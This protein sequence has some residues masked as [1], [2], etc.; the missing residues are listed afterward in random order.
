MEELENKFKEEKKTEQ[1]K[2]KD[3]ENLI[4]N[5]SVDDKTRKTKKES[6]KCSFVILKQLL[7]WDLMKWN[8]KKA[9]KIKRRYTL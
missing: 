9:Y 8:E 5:K 2:I 4:K 7:K 6:L 1:K 3:L